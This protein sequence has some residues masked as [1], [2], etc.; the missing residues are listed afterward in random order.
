MPAF[1]MTMVI[2]TMNRGHLLEHSLYRLL[3]LTTI[4]SEIIVVDDGGDDNTEAICADFS[5]ILPM[6]Y[7]YNHNPGASICSMA[8]NIGLKMAEN[9]WVVTSE[10]ELLY[11]TD[12]LAQ[13][14]DLHEE[15][16]NEIISAGTIFFAPAGWDGSLL[17]PMETA[18]DYQAPSDSQEAI[19][20]VAP[21]TALWY[22]PWLI[23]V[24]GWDETFPGYWGWDDIDLLT[25]LRLNGHGQHIALECEAIHQFHG[26]GGDNNFVNE[27][28]FF[29]KSFTHGQEK[30]HCHEGC[31]QVPEDLTDLVANKGRAW[32]QLTPRS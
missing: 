23:E 32:G 24:G 30:H 29:A 25:R 5:E 28:H 18:G 2:T 21:Y 31:P 20:W 9:D 13:F 10:P 3:N 6:R 1:D 4:P 19:G 8:R 12:I 15:H 14:A 26:L 22:R 7:V 17:A 16:P 27:G 11:R